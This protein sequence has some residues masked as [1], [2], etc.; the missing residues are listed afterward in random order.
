MKYSAQV[1]AEFVRTAQGRIFVLARKPARMVG[2][3]VLIIPPFAE[4]MNKSRKIVTD[5]ALKLAQNGIATI[6]VD[7]FGTGDSEG[8]FRDATWSGWA[9]DVQAAMEWAANNGMPVTKL[10]GIRLGCALGV[11]VLRSTGLCMERVVF[12]QPVMEGKRFLEQFLRLRVAATMMDDDRKETV[13]QLRARVANGEIIEVAGYELT[14]ALVSAIEGARAESLLAIEPCVLD[15]L[16][17]VRATDAPPSVI[18]TKTIDSLRGRSFDVRLRCIA[19][20]SFW[21]SIEIATCR[22]LVDESVSVLSVAA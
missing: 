12:W 2:G 8:E 7:L 13:A 18:A 11:E 20:E 16:E 17:V 22:E 3:A 10:C 1:Q 6:C 9:E 4:E 19:G 14:D 15:W 5:L 21:S